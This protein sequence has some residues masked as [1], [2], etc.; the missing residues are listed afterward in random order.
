MSKGIAG[1]ASPKVRRLLLVFAKNR[2][3]ADSGGTKSK[4]SL[5]NPGVPVPPNCSLL[6]HTDTQRLHLAIKVAAFQAQQLRGMADVVPSRSEER[7]VGKE[8]RSRW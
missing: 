1:D 8:C 5:S 2:S 7:R 3:I 4:T 6:P